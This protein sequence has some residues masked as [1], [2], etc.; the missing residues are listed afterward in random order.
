MLTTT[1]DEQSPRQPQ[2]TRP[3]TQQSQPPYIQSDKAQPSTRQDVLT[4]MSAGSMDV[5]S[6]L[7]PQ[8]QTKMST[9]KMDFSYQGETVQTTTDV[10]PRISPGL[11]GTNQVPQ[12]QTQNMQR[13]PEI[14]TDS[15]DF[16]S[17][18]GK[19]EQQRQPRSFSTSTGTKPMT[20]LQF[21]RTQPTMQK[22]PQVISMFESPPGPRPPGGD[23]G[24]DASRGRPSRESS[25]DSATG[26]PRSRPY[27]E[28][29]PQP[30][31]QPSITNSV[32]SRKPLD[33]TRYVVHSNSLTFSTVSPPSSM[34][35][36]DPS[37][38]VFAPTTTSNASSV[39]TFK[40]DPSSAQMPP[41][42]VERIASTFGTMSFE[43]S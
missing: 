38:N 36:F 15:M 12:A 39:S 1:T 26:L 16:E 23:F 2:K 17:D 13:E 33:Q 42:A 40:S 27:K 5:S 14:A 3:P 20:E 43:S 11:A 30:P 19:P 41:S 4:K 18:W 35:I 21:Q 7:R 25:I 8:A 32:N 6:P 9:G 31:R 24:S 22:Q 37:M 28:A 29:A 34:S 10:K